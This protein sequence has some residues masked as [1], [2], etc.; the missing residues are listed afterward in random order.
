MGTLNCEQLRVD[1]YVID[2]GNVVVVEFSPDDE[3]LLATV[4]VVV[5]LADVVAITTVGTNKA[6]DKKRQPLIFDDD[7]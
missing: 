6:N 7:F 1:G 4:V 3:V 5:V 2:I